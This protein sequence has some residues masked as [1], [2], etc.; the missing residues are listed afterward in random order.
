M[1]RK[2]TTA[3]YVQPYRY[4]SPNVPFSAIR[5]FARRIA[6]RFQPDK[7]ILFG[8]YAYGKPMKRVTSICSLSCGPRT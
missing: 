7:I 5:R 4:A 1:A 6:D 3:Q 2:Q 8:S